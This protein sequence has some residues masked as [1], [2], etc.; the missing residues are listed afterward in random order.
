MLL[1]VITGRGKRNV[2]PPG[3]VH[4]GPEVIWSFPYSG[5]AKDASYIS[6]IRLTAGTRPVEIEG[7]SPARTS[8]GRQN[9]TRPPAKPPVLQVTTM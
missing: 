5:E 7:P 2:W 3:S 8:I 6:L 9:A 4:S 1:E